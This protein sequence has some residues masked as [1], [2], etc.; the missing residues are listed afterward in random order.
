M[1]VY[2]H[3]YMC[4]FAEKFTIPGINR[5]TYASYQRDVRMA[6]LSSVVGSLS[7]AMRGVHPYIILIESD[8][9]NCLDPYLYIY[10][11]THQ[12]WERVALPICTMLPC[13]RV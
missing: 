11:Y 10:I 5:G 6:M 2:I 1:C 9:R 8:R 4:V 3:T 12:N 13:V 7:H